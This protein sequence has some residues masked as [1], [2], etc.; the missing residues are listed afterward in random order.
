MPLCSAV[1]GV[2]GSSKHDRLKLVLYLS[3]S[4]VNMNNMG[5]YGAPGQP[6]LA[7]PCLLVGVTL[8]K[9]SNNYFLSNLVIGARAIELKRGMLAEVYTENRPHFG[10]SHKRWTLLKTVAK[11]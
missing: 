5:D 1:Y 10:L 6:R 11:S 8:R 2:T 7:I 3:D 4:H 9:R